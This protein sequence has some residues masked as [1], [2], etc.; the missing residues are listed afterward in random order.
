MRV[1]QGASLAAGDIAEEKILEERRFNRAGLT[2]EVDV[3]AAIGMSKRKRFCTAPYV[4]VS[5]D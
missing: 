2:D 4:A 3:L 5:H 1:D